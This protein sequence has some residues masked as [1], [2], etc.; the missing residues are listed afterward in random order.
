MTFV[1]GTVL[2]DLSWEEQQRTTRADEL[3]VLG[4]HLRGRAARNIGRAFTV[5]SSGVLSD[6][7]LTPACPSGPASLSRP[8]EKSGHGTQGD[9]ATGRLAPHE[10]PGLR[11]AACS[12][13]AGDSTAAAA[14]I[15]QLH[16]DD[17][18]RH[19]SAEPGIPQRHLH[20]ISQTSNP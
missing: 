12:P 1:C 8:A 6:A 18:D 9:P 14:Q 15:Q 19:R 2:F 17:L 20:L 11:L 3:V 16:A 4:R 10:T 13:C 5:V 7:G